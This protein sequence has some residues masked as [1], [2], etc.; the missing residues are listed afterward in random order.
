MNNV[1]LLSTADLTCQSQRPLLPATIMEIEPPVPLIPTHP[2]NTIRNG[3]IIK[4][5]VSRMRKHGQLPFN[6]APELP[7]RNDKKLAL[8]GQ[9]D[10]PVPSHPR[11]TSVIRRNG[12]GIDQDFH[13][14]IKLPYKCNDILSKRE[15][16]VVSSTHDLK[17][18]SRKSYGLVRAPDG[19]ARIPFFPIEPS[20]AWMSRAYRTRPAWG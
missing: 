4:M 5:H 20:W 3:E 8:L 11:L 2:A 13:D 15:I 14:S 7:F 1:D 12:I 16:E 17:V 9:P 10:T 6:T 19:E 18:F